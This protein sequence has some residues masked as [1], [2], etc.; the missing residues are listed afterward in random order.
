MSWVSKQLKSVGK[1]AKKAG[2]ALGK[3]WEAIDDYALPAI[4]LALALSPLRRL[5][6]VA[7]LIG[8]SDLPL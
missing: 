1:V 7:N 3:G 6:V 5:V 8:S 4:G 2:K